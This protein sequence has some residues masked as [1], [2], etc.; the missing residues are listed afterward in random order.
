MG[1]WKNIEE[2]EEC[3]TLE[4]LEL[5]IKASREK[6]ERFMK[7]YAAFKGV[8]LDESDREEAEERFKK[9][10]RR[11]EARLAG[12]SDEEIEAQQ[13]ISEFADFGLEVETID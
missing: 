3:L 8:D 2:L 11:A 10:Q 13:E 6:E 5:I 12:L 9:A 7:F 4:E 1:K